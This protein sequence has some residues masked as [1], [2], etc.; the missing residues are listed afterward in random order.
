MIYY[1]I[2]FM[3]K[4]KIKQSKCILIVEMTI[5]YRRQLVTTITNS[6]A[7]KDKNC[8]ILTNFSSLKLEKSL[9]LRK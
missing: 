9:N 7:L 1:K 5:Q 2:Q 3:V 8:F 6:P 4:L